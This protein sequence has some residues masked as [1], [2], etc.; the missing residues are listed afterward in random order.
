MTTLGELLG[1]CLSAVGVSRAYGIPVPGVAVHPVAHSGAAV[2]MAAAH[3]RLER[4]VGAALPDPGELWL[5]SEP[6][7][8]PESSSMAVG[9]PGG[10]VDA[11][12]Y[13]AGGVVAAPGAVRIHLD[14]DLAAPAPPGPDVAEV[15]R[16]RDPGAGEVPDDVVAA[17]TAAE[18]PVVLAGPG[19]VWAGREAVAGLRAVAEAA[20]VGVLNTWGAKGLFHWS[21]PHHL[22]TAGL[23]A[24]D[25]E[26]AGFAEADLIVATG[27][28]PY[29]APSQLWHLAPFV[30]VD[31]LAL[32]GLARR[33]R[34]P[35]RPI[36]T[37]P[38]RAL[39]TEVVA[40]GSQS[41]AVPLA[42]ARAVVDAAA[43]LGSGGLVAADPGLAGL[44]VA[45]TFAT[46]ELGSVA[47]PARAGT[48]G[49]AAALAWVSRLLHPERRA[50]AVVAEVDA[51]TAA[52]LEEARRG[53][54]GP[55]VEVWDPD[56][57]R[58]APE[59][60]AAALDRGLAGAG[61]PEVL[62]TPV[63]LTHTDALVDIAGPV[64]AW[65]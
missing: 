20:S 23:Q 10:L 40:A 55:V 22:A 19:V 11:V 45:R 36:E 61:P 13:A 26:L 6:G 65:T 3:A 33:W 8:T 9:D 59:A 62:Q 17:A 18:H 4:G 25:F 1:E 53:G 5:V 15:V 56:A 21:S 16:R 60:R 64:V 7:C 44:W 52:I 47:V 12:A 34:C 48:G 24:R 29:E 57:P 54:V 50:L 43:A 39:L 37:V 63:D 35:S 42:P 27:V 14:L 28:D 46:T 49:W 51:A 32:A 41:D 2:L 31:P 58:V 30:E 38:L